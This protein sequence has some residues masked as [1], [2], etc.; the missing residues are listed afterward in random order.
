MERSSRGGGRGPSN[1]K[2]I[3]VNYLLLLAVL[4]SLLPSATAT[5]QDANDLKPYPAAQ[6]G[7][8]RA[9]FR[10][11][12]L[13]NEADRMVEILV[14]KI[15]LVDCNRTWFGGNLEKRVVE[16]WG[17]PY[18]VLEEAGPPAST[19]MACPP[20]QEKTEAFVPVRGEGF[21]VR[22]NSKLPVVTYLPEGFEVRYRIW[23]AG[24]EVIPP[25]GE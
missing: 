3:V 11:P 18:F 12:A 21:L 4:A 13:D 7:L 16:G 10:L 17:Y 19:M 5:A 14:G 1:Q 22:Y 8:V 2:E 6:K 20:E 15:L 25:H 9:A 24:D 23:A